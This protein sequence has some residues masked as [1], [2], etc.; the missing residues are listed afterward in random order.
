MIT[1]LEELHRETLKDYTPGTVNYFKT[2]YYFG[3]ALSIFGAERLIA[4]HN[5]RC[6]TEEK[7]KI[8]Q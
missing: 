2:E 7:G 6:I 8:G 4:D 1:T 5:K 3:Q